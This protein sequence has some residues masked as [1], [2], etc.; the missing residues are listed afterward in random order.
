MITRVLRW[1]LVIFILIPLGLTSIALAVVVITGAVG[2]WALTQAVDGNPNQYG[3]A[4]WVAGRLG[5][6]R[7]Q[8]R[9]GLGAR[10]AGVARSA[11]RTREGPRRRRPTP[12]DFGRAARTAAPALPAATG[13]DGPKR[14]LVAALNEA[15]MFGSGGAL[16][17]VA[18]VE[19]N[20][21][22]RCP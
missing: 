19:F 6:R 12:V 20:G 11:R 5:D 16:L 7:R 3:R 13:A 4:A 10:A 1:L 9:P 17:Y 14:Y 2:G 21:A 15:E 22:H 18:M 8:R